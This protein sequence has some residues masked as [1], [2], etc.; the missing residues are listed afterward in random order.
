MDEIHLS[1]FCQPGFNEWME[2]H[3][4][5]RF[6][7]VG[8]GDSI[9][10][11]EMLTDMASGVLVGVLFPIAMAVV[12]A[13]PLIFFALQIAGGVVGAIALANDECGGSIWTDPSLPLVITSV[14][15]LFVM[16]CIFT[17]AVV[18][19]GNEELEECEAGLRCS[20]C[21]CPLILCSVCVQKNASLFLW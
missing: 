11:K 12:I 18:D 17:L 10:V 15:S 1:P 20:I 16:I 21:V 4:P 8:R 7:S 6:F 2:S 5:A 19:C 13:I 3:A 9:D 14:L